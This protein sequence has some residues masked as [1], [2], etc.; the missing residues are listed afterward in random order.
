VLRATLVRSGEAD[1]SGYTLVLAPERVYVARTGSELRRVQLMRGTR[2]E[3]VDGLFFIA[4]HHQPGELEELVVDAA[5]S[6]DRGSALTLAISSSDGPEGIAYAR[7]GQS[8]FS[9]N[10]RRR[11]VPIWRAA[12]SVLHAFSRVQGASSVLPSHVAE[13][14]IELWREHEGAVLELEGGYR[15]ENALHSFRV[16][17]PVRHGLQRVYMLD[18]SR[19]ELEW[20]PGELL[21][22][23]ERE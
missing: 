17:S 23:A 7:V 20:G 8:F 3:E 5:L 22:P 13:Q 15:A 1:G 9:T 4:R 21:P 12:G 19:V 16:S 11:R 18:G 10:R 6:P 2:P 14:M